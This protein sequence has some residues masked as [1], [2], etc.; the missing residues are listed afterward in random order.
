MK[1][2]TEMMSLEGKRKSWEETEGL[3]EKAWFAMPQASYGAQNMN[4]QVESHMFSSEE[5]RRRL[6]QQHTEKEGV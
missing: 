1:L 3:G 4:Q 2:D 6:L 5:G